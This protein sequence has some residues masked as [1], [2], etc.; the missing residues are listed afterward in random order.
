MA[1][2]GGGE[3]ARPHEKKRRVHAK[4]GGERELQH[5]LGQGTGDWF[6]LVDDAALEMV[7]VGEAED[8][9]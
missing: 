8:E 3:M 4:N 9:G 6:V 2:D 1:G 7:E 5:D